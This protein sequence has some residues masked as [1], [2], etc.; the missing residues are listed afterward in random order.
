MI[1]IEI[2]QQVEPSMGAEAAA[3]CQL[4]K[5]AL[6]QCVV[7]KARYRDGRVREGGFEPGATHA[8]PG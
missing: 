7:D 3:G 6:V 8:R 2:Y 4:I 1:R 5:V